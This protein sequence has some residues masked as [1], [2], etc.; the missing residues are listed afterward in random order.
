[1]KRV[2]PR[3]VVPSTTVRDAII[4]AVAG[5]LVL[6]FIIYG[7]FHFA[8]ASS[9]AKA[10]TATGTIIEK[11]FTPAPEE[12]I[13]VGRK[14]LKAK[15][16][17]GEFVLKVRVEEENREFEVPVEKKVFEAKK[18]GDSLSFLRPPSERGR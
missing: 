3:T 14:G 10:A 6:A 15:A 9:R 2:D 7:F 17:E 13:S 1:M 18:V 5:L 8:T 16:I 4:A 12:Q 11:V